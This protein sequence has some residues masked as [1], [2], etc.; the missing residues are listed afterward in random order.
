MANIWITATRWLTVPLL[1]HA[2]P[3]AARD[4]SPWPGHYYL[5][6]VMETGSELL[7]QA[8][9]RFQWYL[10]YGAL[11]LFAQ[12]RWTQEGDRIILIAKPSGDIPRPGFDRLEL[13]PRDGALIPPDGC[14]AYEKAQAHD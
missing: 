10:V 1:L 6:G 11:D 5:Q 14:G 12:G 9:G 2:A 4:A 7:L 8:D 13:T 3:L